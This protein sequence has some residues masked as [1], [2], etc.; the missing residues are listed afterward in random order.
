LLP[1]KIIRIDVLLLHFICP[2]C[3][4]SPSIKGLKFE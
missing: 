3:F 1:D 4:S 2:C